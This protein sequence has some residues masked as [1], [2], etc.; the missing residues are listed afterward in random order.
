MMQELFEQLLGA[1]EDDMEIPEEE[2]TGE[3]ITDI[4]IFLEQ[5]EEA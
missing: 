2:L 3:E 1:S 5:G 4:Q